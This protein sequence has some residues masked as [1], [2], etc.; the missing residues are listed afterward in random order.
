MP[1]E[2]AEASSDATGALCQA[3]VKVG[4]A[5]KLETIPYVISPSA[6]LQMISESHTVHSTSW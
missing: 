4:K 3:P 1:A 5:V 6:E 2:Q